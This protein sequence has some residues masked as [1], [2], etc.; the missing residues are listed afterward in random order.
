MAN[1]PRVSYKRAPSEELQRLLMHGMVCHGWWNWAKRKSRDINMMC[2]F[3]RETRC[4]F[5][6]IEDF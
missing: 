6:V 5:I 3:V 1:T 4:K 2:T